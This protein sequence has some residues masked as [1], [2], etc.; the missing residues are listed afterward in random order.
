MYVK[1]TKNVFLLFVFFKSVS[2]FMLSSNLGV[3]W[4]VMEEDGVVYLLSFQVS[5]IL[6]C[7]Q[8]CRSGAAD[9]GGV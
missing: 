2:S 6:H 5:F 4:P 8:Q 3:R 7:V 1:H 9:S